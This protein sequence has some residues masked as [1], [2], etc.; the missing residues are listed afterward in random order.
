MTLGAWCPWEANG[1]RHR[2]VLAAIDV[3]LS[4]VALAPRA[5]CRPDADFWHPRTPSSTLSPR[6]SMEHVSIE[7]IVLLTLESLNFVSSATLSLAAAD[8]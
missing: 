5:G 4:V 1:P 8:T 3:S 2:V 7:Y 6:A